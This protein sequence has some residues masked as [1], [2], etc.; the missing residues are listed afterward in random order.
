VWLFTFLRCWNGGAD[1]VYDVAIVG[2]GVIGALTA[3]ELSRYDLEICI[4]EKGSDVAC[5]TSKANSAIVHAGYD[6]VPGTLKAI[7]NIKGNELFEGISKELDVPFRRIGSLVLAFN[8]SDMD[9]VAELYER[10]IRSNVPDLRMLDSLEEILKVEPNVSHDVVGALYAPS[11][12]ITCP[13]ELTYGAVE[14]AVVNKAEL[15]LE[16]EVTGITFENEVF[17]L[18]TNRGPVCSRFVVNAAGVSSDVVAGMIGDRSFKIKPRK[19]EYM[20]LDKNQGGKARTVVFKTPSAAGKGIL[21]TP[22]VDGNLLIGPTSAEIDD[23]EDLAT[24]S[25]GL[26]QVVD[27]AMKSIYGIDPRQVITSF[28]GL[29]ASASEPDFII[30]PSL[31]NNRLINAAGIDSPGLTAAPAIAGYIAE[32]LCD[33]GLELRPKKDFYPYRKSIKR[34]NEAQD[35]EKTELI[36]QNRLYGRIICR[37]ELVTEAEIVEAIRRPAGA[38]TVDAVKRRT[39]A[40]MGRCQG[41]FCTP[42]ITEI[43]SRELNIPMERVTKKGSGSELLAGRTKEGLE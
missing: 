36:R 24:T 30:L 4:L 33:S 6:P 2:A 42:W 28:A 5:G 17:K 14:N 27:G 37:C 7:L 29:R 13:Y 8:E 16:T 21:V 10:G 35:R 12:G 39:R 25:E 11:A 19:G 38:R 22:T 32:L 20:L 23:R 34:F 9:T 41:G 43:L 31:I 26:Q 15:M 3:R 40:G 1:V 18:E